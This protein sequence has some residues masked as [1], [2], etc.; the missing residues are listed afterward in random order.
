MLR[1]TAYKGEAIWGKQQNV[2]KTTRRRRPEHEW[3]RLA[4]PSII[5]ADTFE[6]VQQALRT[7]QRVASRNRKDEY[8]L[9]GGRLRCGRCGRGMSSLC[10]QR[11]YRYYLCNSQHQLT[12]HTL[13]CPGSVRADV[14]EP[15]VWGAVMRVLEQPELIAAEVARHEAHAD[16]QRS[17]MAGQLALTRPHWRSATEKPS[18][19]LMPMRVRSSAWPS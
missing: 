9:F 13:R 15:E 14:I 6:A 1:N 10:R 16:E 5:D 12:D 4:V 17:A 11:Q 19:G 8:L 7:H 2:T 3:V 18:A